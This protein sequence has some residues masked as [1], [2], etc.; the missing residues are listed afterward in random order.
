MKF[1]LA[2]LMQERLGQIKKIA[3]PRL[4]GYQDPE[5]FD[6]FIAPTL[7]EEKKSIFDQD[8]STR[9]KD[10][11]SSYEPVVIDRE[12]EEGQRVIYVLLERSSFDKD[13]LR[14]PY[15][16]FDS[17]DDAIKKAKELKEL[18]LN[19]ESTEFTVMSLALM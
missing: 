16:A 17:K 9:P 2:K 10:D 14:N 5:Y 1:D 13:G 19:D 7:E 18:S 3:S 15:A 8:Y 12:H 4:K 6:E 11:D